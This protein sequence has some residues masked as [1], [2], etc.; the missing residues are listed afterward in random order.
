ML[1]KLSCKGYLFSL[2]VLKRLSF[3]ETVLFKVDSEKKKTKA[4][5]PSILLSNEK[6]NVGISS[7]P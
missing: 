5:E 2:G 1:T 3:I 4:N 6:C 7:Y